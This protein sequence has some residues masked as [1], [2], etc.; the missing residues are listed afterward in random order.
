MIVGGGSDDMVDAVES[1]PRTQMSW[2]S[3][4]AA[5]ALKKLGSRGFGTSGVSVTSRRASHL[6]GTAA[7]TVAP[8]PAASAHR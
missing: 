3:G 4:C 1:L 6:S 8:S 7:L 2:Y 5:S